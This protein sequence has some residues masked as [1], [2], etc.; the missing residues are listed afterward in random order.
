[1]L[2]E[3]LAQL[4]SRKRSVREEAI[5]EARALPPEQLLELAEMQTTLYK[6]RLRQYNC[7]LVGLVV[8]WLALMLARFYFHFPAPWQIVYLSGV[9]A[10]LLVPIRAQ[11]SVAKLIEEVTDLRFIG[12]VL[13]LL[14]QN[15]VD[16]DVKK[17][18]RIVLKRLLP[19][20][21]ADEANTLT[22]EQRQ[23][24][25]PPLASPYDDV[26]LSLAI[27]KALEQIGDE[28]AIPV[29]ERL[30]QEGKATRNMQRITEA[31]KDCLP[32]LKLRVEQQQ[33]AQTLLRASD[34]ATVTTLDVL[35]RPAMAAANETPSDE[36]L[37]AVPTEPTP[38]PTTSHNHN[39]TS[40]CLLIHRP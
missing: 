20:L 24:L 26:E 15:I 12:P 1:M 40:E 10:G 21:R 7:T 8:I 25:L 32:Y 4:N 22:P 36:L 13:S 30:T 5:R 35:L 11:R 3:L 33:Q 14:A 6:R 31:A 17:S 39:E 34:S 2:E 16:T 18:A 28:K 37:R 27:L 9:I 29:V 23:A 38:T 19:Q